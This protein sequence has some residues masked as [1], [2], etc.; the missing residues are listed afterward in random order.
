M[1][2]CLIGETASPLTAIAHLKQLCG[3]PSL[4]RDADDNKR[5]TDT[6]IGDSAKL[7][8]LFDLVQRLKRAGHR[9]LIFSQSTKMLDIIEKVFDGYV[10]FLRI[11]GQTAEKFR[12]RNVDHFNDLS[13]G[14]DCM[15]LSTKAAGVGIT[16]NGANRAII[17]DPSWNPAEDMQAIDRCYR[18]GQT[19]NV[20]V[21][22]FITSGTVE[23]KMYEKQGKTFGTSR[24]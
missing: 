1:P 20:T 5:D 10:S 24:L 16:L 11:D 19:R 12:Q 21:Y 7:Q 22:R 3:H 8:V 18:I 6:L 14:I 23:E 15:L 2:D 9:S 4:V 13:S 17:Y